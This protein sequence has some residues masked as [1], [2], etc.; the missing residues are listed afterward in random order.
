MS[1]AAFPGRAGSAGRLP[2]ST[3]GA[4]WRGLTGTAGW[5]WLAGGAGGR[6]APAVAAARTQPHGMR[7]A[8]TAPAPAKKEDPNDV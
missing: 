8:A 4:G 6:V 2:G 5:Q 3:G 1:A 7:A